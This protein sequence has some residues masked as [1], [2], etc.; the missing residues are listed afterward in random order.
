[1]ARASSFSPEVRERSVRL[2]LENG[3][4]HPSR[5]AAVKSVAEKLGCS[6]ETLRKWI[7]AFERD[8]GKRDDAL[9]AEAVWMSYPQHA[10]GHDC[11][12]PG[13]VPGLSGRV[14]PGEEAGAATRDGRW[15]LHHRARSA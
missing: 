6:A 9:R 5:W 1:M 3:G 13:A 4:G 11:L 12:V 8:Q 10:G 7:E 15:R 14:A 2:V